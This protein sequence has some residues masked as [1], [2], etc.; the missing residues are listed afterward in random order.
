MQGTVKI[1]DKNVLMVANAA[2]VY[3]YRSIFKED[4]LVKA[5][6]KNPDPDIFQKMGFVMAKQAET[7]KMSELMNITIDEFYDWLVQFEPLDILTAAG[8]ISNLYM[9]QTEG[10]S[11]PK[12]KG[13]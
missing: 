6:D 5:Q 12:R 2:S 10:L 9:G 11:T 8:E 13:V 7:N 3:V 4:F 1:G